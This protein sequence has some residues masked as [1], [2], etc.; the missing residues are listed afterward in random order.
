M[1]R[2]SDLASPESL[3][4]S[5]PSGQKHLYVFAA[6]PP[7]P[8]ADATLFQEK[9]APDR[10]WGWEIRRGRHFLILYFLIVSWAD[11]KDWQT[12]T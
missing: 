11:T 4:I 10:P 5:D 12:G 1:S 7:L 2:P 8:E 6:P 3:L 9:T